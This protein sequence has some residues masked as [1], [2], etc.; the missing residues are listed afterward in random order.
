[1]A[2][3]ADTTADLGACLRPG[4][5]DGRLFGSPVAAAVRFRGE[6]F[7]SVVWDVDDALPGQSVPPGA[8][9][10]DTEP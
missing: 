2:K 7:V 4:T 5:L 3:E 9:G 10:A 1:M 6:L 8:G